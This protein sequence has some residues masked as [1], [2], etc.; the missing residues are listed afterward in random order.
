MYLF[1]STGAFLDLTLAQH[2]GLI[3]IDMSRQ[4]SAN[5]A[6][7]FPAPGVMRRA[8]KSIDGPLLGKLM[9]TF[10]SVFF[11]MLK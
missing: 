11:T 8:L 9:N 2:N 10:A 3:A 7:F 4:S 5:Y 6:K 1:L